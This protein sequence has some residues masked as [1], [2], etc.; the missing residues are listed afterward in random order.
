[1]LALTPEPSRILFY[2]DRLKPNHSLGTSLVLAA[3]AFLLLFASPAFATD[4]PTDQST[5]STPGASFAMATRVARL[6]K[7]T[8]V[9]SPENVGIRLTE[10]P[11]AL[12]NDPRARL[13]I[14]DRVAP[15]TTFS[16]KIEIE[17][18]TSVSNVIEVYVAGAAI[19]DGAFVGG[20]G[21]TPNELSTWVTLSA[22]S[23]SLRAR[24]VSNVIATIAVP[25]D[26][27]AG[28]RYAVVW[29]QVKTPSK[30][31]GIITINRVGIRIYLSVGEG[32]EPASSFEIK[33][34]AATREAD[35]TPKVLA[36]V[37]NTGG[38]A[39]DISGELSLIDGPG[40]SSAGPFAVTLG[41]TLAIGATET[42][43]IKLPRALPAGPWLATLTLHSGLLTE[44]A[45]ATIKFPDVGTSP[46]VPV[47]GSGAPLLVWVLPSILAA[48]LIAAAI[49]LWQLNIR[50]QKLN[51]GEPSKLRRKRT[52]NN[53]HSRHQHYW[54]LTNVQN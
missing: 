29:A 50:R 17:N 24:K 54:F 8:P 26:A 44:T 6:A 3:A 43:N 30:T 49:G 47:A 41:T 7:P 48:L 5:R 27:S 2:N 1:L 32:G 16:R 53:G 13:Y 37:T 31:T 9:A 40:G 28:E 39:L 36:L 11:E 10:V 38:R 45:S 14:I 12:A 33:S 42:V 25:A 51:I 52:Y 34:L 20:E 46:P 15:G 18:D 21:A 19:V 23:V 22:P 35:G 4:A